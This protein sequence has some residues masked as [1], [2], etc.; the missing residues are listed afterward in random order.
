[1]GCISSKN[2]NLK[3]E[4]INRVAPEQQNDREPKNTSTQE[5]T[6]IKTTVVAVNCNPIPKKNDSSQKEE[7]SSSKE[8]TKK[9]G[10]F[11]LSITKS[12]TMPRNQA[13]PVLRINKP[14]RRTEASTVN[15]TGTLSN[16]TIVEV[17][18]FNDIVPE[19]LL[20]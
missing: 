7:D 15:K 14:K 5:A 19:K 18:E 8:N 12:T 11:P 3:K 9:I 1:M 4:P 10:N 17:K 13:L 2:S 20:P 16:S 6:P